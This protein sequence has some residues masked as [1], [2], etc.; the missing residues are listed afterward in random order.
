MPFISFPFW[1][2][3]SH[4]YFSSHFFH[5]SYLKHYYCKKVGVLEPPQPRCSAGPVLECLIIHLR[6]KKNVKSCKNPFRIC[7]FSPIQLV[8]LP[9]SFTRINLDSPP[10][11]LVCF[12]FSFARIN[13]DSCNSTGENLCTD[14]NFNP[15]TLFLPSPYLCENRKW[16]LIKQTH[17]CEGYTRSTKNQ[18]V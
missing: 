8:C 12:P 10:I 3:F 14:E 4:I 17:F 18:I 5:F 6:G 2:S 9:F 13:F 11:Q 16:I 7:G 15:A 1:S